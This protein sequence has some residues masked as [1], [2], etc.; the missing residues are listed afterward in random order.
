MTHNTLCQLKP[1]KSIGSDDM[2]MTM[3][4]KCAS[5]IAP[6]LIHLFTISFEN[7]QIPSLRKLAIIIPI[8]KQ[9]IF[10][11]ASNILT[12]FAKVQERLFCY[13]LAAYR[14]NQFGFRPGTSTLHAHS[15]MHDFLTSIHD[16]SHIVGVSVTS[17]DLSKA[18]DRLSHSSLIQ[19]FIRNKLP[20]IL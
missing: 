18:F 9:N 12:P 2:P 3:I 19:T 16:K 8:L 14:D 4:R 1:N 20:L 15:K 6:P 7:E 11:P 17:L 13:L 5:Y 10:R